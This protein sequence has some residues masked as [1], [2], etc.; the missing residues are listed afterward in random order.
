MTI[1]GSHSKRMKPSRISRRGGLFTECGLKARHCERPWTDAFVWEKKKK[2]QVLVT[3]SCMTLCSS[4]DYSSPGSS[5]HGVLQARI[6]EQVAIS[7]SRGSSQAR[8]RTQVSWIVGR[9]FTIW[10]PGKK[11]QNSPTNY[12][13]CRL[14][15]HDQL[16]RFCVCG[17][18]K[19]SLRAPTKENSLVLIAVNIGART[20]RSRTRL[21]SELPP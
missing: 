19:R 14:N 7:F 21:E 17:I 1:G 20:Q 2:V 6:L 3:Q 13:T 4:I 15:P 9:R 16:G 12:T 10:P 5:V 11:T 18:Y 8:D